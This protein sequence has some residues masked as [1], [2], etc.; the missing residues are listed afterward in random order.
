MKNLKIAAFVS[1]ALYF[2]LDFVY[3]WN[4]ILLGAFYDFAT[5]SDLTSWHLHLINKL[6]VIDQYQVLCLYIAVPLVLIYLF[7]RLK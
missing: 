1:V 7:K 3:E 4:R 5:I 2:V 6:Y